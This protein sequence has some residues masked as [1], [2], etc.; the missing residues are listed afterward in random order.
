MSRTDLINYLIWLRNFNNYLEISIH[1]EQINFTTVK[2]HNKLIVNGYQSNQF[3]KKNNKQFDIVFI[4]GVHTEEQALK[5]IKHGLF[6]LTKEGIIVI[7]DC[8]P[9][10]EWHQ[11]ELE[12]YN[13]GEN[14]NGTV[15]KAALRV[16][17]DSRFHCVLLD[18]DWG[19][20]IIDTSKTS[21]SLSIKLPQKLNY[22]LHFSY[23][24]KYK[25]SV[26]TY[27]R[28]NL[29]VFYHLACM[30]NWM[31]IYQE[32]ITHLKS[33]GFQKISLTILGNKKDIFIANDLLKELDFQ[34]NV[35]FTAPELTH[36]EKPALMA[37]ENYAK[38]NN[39][40]VL[41]LHSKGVSAPSNDIKTK[42]RRLMMRELVENWERC[43][44]QLLN[45]D[46]IGVNWR[47]M[48]DA[49]HYSGNFW[50]AS[51]SYI[52]QLEDFNHY[53]ENPRYKIWDA[54]NDKRLGCEFW[55]GSGSKKPR[56]LS[57]YCRNVDFCNQNYWRNKDIR[58]NISTKMPCLMT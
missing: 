34:Y 16:F 36:F 52:R 1:D 43:V 47:D 49:S 23:L 27:L 11:R 22:K 50:F 29:K 38:Q 15:W 20:G 45:Y 6:C 40:Y 35:L 51:T 57:L 30:G 8:L 4:D 19:C 7:H 42:W 26:P 9:P 32:Q 10:D 28:D 17:N 46:V 5:D 39:G 25:K 44:M 58:L 37:I 41:Y 31:D 13:A 48:D 56:L 55:I 18:T 53:Y 33:N 54:V 14:W 2:C 24:L 21:K 12:K 3:F